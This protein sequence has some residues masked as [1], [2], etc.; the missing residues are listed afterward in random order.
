MTE[1]EKTSLE[2]EQENRARAEPVKCSIVLD[3][4]LMK[5]IEEVGQREG[6]SNVSWLVRKLLRLGIESYY[7]G[8]RQPPDATGPLVVNLPPPVRLLLDQL[9]HRSAVD[10]ASLVAG[11]V[12]E[13]LPVWVEQAVADDQKLRDLINLLMVPRPS[14]PPERE[15]AKGQGTAGE[16][17]S[18]EN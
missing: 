5:K 3:Q 4:D 15:A 7:E 16:G 9:G 10:P 8:F 11:M 14:T 12:R 17:Q 1:N 6:N 13:R 18:Q 2:L